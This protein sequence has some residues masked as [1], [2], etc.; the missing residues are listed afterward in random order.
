MPAIQE[1]ID[2]RICPPSSHLFH[3]EGV[4][5]APEPHCAAC[6][7]VDELIQELIRKQLQEANRS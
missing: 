5:S 7:M 3:A 1:K 4:G 6:A 2:N